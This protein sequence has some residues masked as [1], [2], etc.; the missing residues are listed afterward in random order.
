[1]AGGQKFLD[2]AFL[3][4]AATSLCRTPA[5]D[6]ALAATASTDFTRRWGIHIFTYHTPADQDGTNR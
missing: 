1:M 4:L 6:F 2:S 3:T 5:A